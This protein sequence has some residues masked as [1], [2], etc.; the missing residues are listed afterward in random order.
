MAWLADS[1]FLTELPTPIKLSLVCVLISSELYLFDIYPSVFRY[2]T[3]LF[4]LN[5][6]LMKLRVNNFKILAYMALG[7]IMLYFPLTLC[8][9]VGIMTILVVYYGKDQ[10]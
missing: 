9:Y 3:R 1:T 2:V 8:V 7:L 6:G 5:L 4:I 10:S